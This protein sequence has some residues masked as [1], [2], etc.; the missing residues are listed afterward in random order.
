LFCFVLFC[1]VLFCFVLFCFV[2]FCFVL[3]CF[4]LFCFVLFCFVRWICH[5]RRSSDL[6]A[7]TFFCAV[8]KSTYPLFNT[9]Q[10]GAVSSL[11]SESCSMFFHLQPFSKYFNHPLDIFVRLMKK[12]DMECIN[13]LFWDVR[14]KHIS[15]SNTLIV[16]FCSTHINL[17]EC[18]LLTQNDQ[19]WFLPI[20]VWYFI[21]HDQ[22]PLVGDTSNWSANWMGTTTLPPM[23]REPNIAGVPLKTLLQRQLYKNTK[24][25][26]KCELQELDTLMMNQRMG[27]VVSIQY[28]QVQD[29]E[30]GAWTQIPSRVDLTTF[31]WYVRVQD[32]QWRSECDDLEED[33]RYVYLILEPSH[34]R[35]KKN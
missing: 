31:L 26:S 32:I 28:V 23:N 1:F 18:S 17:I 10:K 29:V 35:K 27:V 16:S 8:R 6:S 3:F 24:K 34:K 30:L 19:L 2:L 9:L 11:G 15:S 22:Q 14:V 21:L 5:S 7:L 12:S 13:T 33:M 20:S 25:Y 4:V